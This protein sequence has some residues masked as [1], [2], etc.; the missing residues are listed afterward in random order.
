M[1]IELVD[2]DFG[3]DVLILSVLTGYIPPV[4]RRSSQRWCRRVEPTKRHSCTY[5]PSSWLVRPCTA[6]R[7]RESCRPGC[8]TKREWDKGVGGMRRLAVESEEG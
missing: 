3:K 8:S 7:A 5:M 1:L 6:L 4:D 2:R